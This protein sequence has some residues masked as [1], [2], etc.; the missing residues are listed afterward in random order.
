MNKQR[1]DIDLYTT[2]GVVKSTIHGNIINISCNKNI[3]YQYRQIS[4][5]NRNLSPRVL[6]VKENGTARAKESKENRKKRMTFVP[7]KDRIKAKLNAKSDARPLV[8]EEIKNISFSS[9]MANMEQDNLP[10]MRLKKRMLLKAYFDQ[11]RLNNLKAVKS[12]FTLKKS[13][14]NRNQVFV[15][16][17]P[18]VTNVNKVNVLQQLLKYKQYVTKKWDLKVKARGT[19][20]NFIKTQVSFDKQK[21]RNLAQPFYMC[22]NQRVNKQL[23]TLQKQKLVLTTKA[24]LQRFKNQR[25]IFFKS[26]NK[27]DIDL[28]F[29]ALKKGNKATRAKKKKQRRVKKKVKVM[30]VLEELKDFVASEEEMEANYKT[31]VETIMSSIVTNYTENANPIILKNLQQQ[32]RVQEYLKFSQIRR[33]FDITNETELSKTKELKKRDEKKLKKSIQQKFIKTVVIAG[34]NKKT[35]QRDSKKEVIIKVLLNIL[36]RK[37]EVPFEGNI[38]IPFPYLN[39]LGRKQGDAKMN[40]LALNLQ[41]RI[42][43]DL[44]NYKGD[45]DV[46]L[47]HVALVRN[48]IAYLEYMRQKP[49]KPRNAGK[50]Y[51]YSPIGK[52]N[53][54]GK[55]MYAKLT[56]QKNMLEKAALK[57]NYNILNNII[58]SEQKVYKLRLPKQRVTVPTL[59]QVYERVINHIKGLEKRTQGVHAGKAKV[60][61]FQ[62]LIRKLNAI[63][64]N[65]KGMR[66]ERRVKK[67]QEETTAPVNIP[68]NQGVLRITLKKKNMFLVLQNLSTKHIDTTV[69]ARQEYYRIYNTKEI[70]P[71]TTKKKQALKVTAIKPLGP[72]GRVIGTDLFRRRVIT[73]VLL[74]LKAQIKYNVLDIEIRNP[75]VHSIINT[76]LYKHWYIYEDQGI[77]RM[78]KFTKNKAHGIRGSSPLWE[79]LITQL[80][81][82]FV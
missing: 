78:Y 7:K 82:V 65:K 23:Q 14:L 29:I 74:N 9:Q 13:I 19:K 56:E 49:R 22:L 70:D 12:T 63:K 45:Q 34:L 58:E 79:N 35:Q 28:L 48:R 24:K 68:L 72:I 44:L 26:Q 32:L 25:D 31:P 81:R 5:T 4:N 36:R 55:M 1:T 61:R 46:K 39:E 17:S 42:I 6:N 73:Q 69:T 75:G 16:Y 21:V 3:Q 38:E 2:T 20:S 66:K 67:A 33:L 51:D 54:L 59:Y 27:V 8:V 30:K 47:N 41:M 64:R 77:L 50:F 62:N 11:L 18:K 53:S 15:T 76:I 10:M 57:N 71:L 80:V 37:G 40:N 52:A 43:T 60:K